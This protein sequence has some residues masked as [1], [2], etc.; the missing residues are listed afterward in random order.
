[1]KALQ[2]LELFGALDA[3]TLNELAGAMDSLACLPEQAL[4]R[5]GDPGDAMFIV[6]SG[7]FRVA[8]NRPDGEVMMLGE[9]G[10]GQP[11]GEI[12]LFAG[13][14]RSAT[15]VA[16]IDS[17]VFRLP[18]SAID[19]LGEA[20][21]AAMKGLQDMIRQRLWRN[22]LASLL[23]A[24]IGPLDVD[25][26]KEFEKKIEWVSL[27]RGEPLFRQGEPGDA[28]YI[29]ARG[30]LQVVVTDEHGEEQV[31]RE[32]GRGESLGEIALLTEEPRSATPY[33]MRDSE[34]IRI[35]KADFDEIMVRYPRVL[36]SIAQT[37]MKRSMKTKAGRRRKRAN[38]NLAVIG[39][40]PGAPTSWFAEQL[41]RSFQAVGP[42]LHVNSERLA[43]LGVME[44][45]NRVTADDDPS[46]LRFSEWA[47][48]QDSLFDIIILEGD[49]SSTA[50]T[51]RAIRQADHVLVVADAGSDPR[52]GGLEEQLFGADRRKLR[53]TH[54]SLVLVHPEQ[55]R[56]PSGTERWLRPRPGLKAHHHVRRGGSADVDRIAR[57]LGG[58]G[59]GVV[60]GGGGAR[61]F[62][63]VGIVQAMQQLGIPIDYLG[64]TSMGAILSA[65]FAMG[66][67][68]QQTLELNLR[69]TRT[70][71]FSE[72][73][74]PLMS[75][76]RSRRLEA[77]ARM[78]FGDVRLEDL[79]TPYF[80][81]SANLT[82]AEMVVHDRGVLWEAIR[83]SGALPG[84][85]LPV[86]LGKTLLV[87]GGV[88]NNLPGDVMRQRCGGAMLAVDVSP[89]EDVSVGLEGFPSPWRILL[90]RVLPLQKKLA[91]PSIADIL[92]RTL[93]LG[94][95]SR[96]YQ[97]RR[98]A[99][100]YL[101]PPI[102]R[103]G[104][105]EFHSMKEIAAVG[106]QYGLQHLPKWKAEW[107]GQLKAL[108]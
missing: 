13:G 60:M 3:A 62:A 41:A 10:P 46:W 22:E 6:T 71:P 97:V 94:S 30:R 38:L 50:W 74:L 58:C 39:A 37:L 77:G 35:G 48:E 89:E 68:V 42:T 85:L 43:R 90:N 16:E 107:D 18:R 95:A 102:D 32:M 53:G 63:H 57:L 103:F 67:T 105:L 29:I 79:W 24:I 78:S 1:M 108:L 28:W 5:Q 76:L 96:T 15:V 54:L 92:M 55:T 36:M 21:R 27:P 4:V 49:P 82:T 98:D 56:L 40:S 83:A 86:V 73:T 14:R 51:Q 99:D 52:V 87:D 80:C 69:V 70:R 2:S 12:Q 47:E 44:N 100:L 33:A 65:Q 91:V 11:I 17:T 84:I 61:G 8:V 104:M 20:P 88:I 19:R 93:M 72:Y 34:V 106:F 25:V 66:L 75:V 7:R 81:I 23:P 64:G 31:L 45:I 9:L 59:I 101:R 26:I